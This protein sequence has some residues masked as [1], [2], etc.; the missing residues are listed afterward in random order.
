MQN[1]IWISQ[2][3]FL[4]RK[5]SPIIFFVALLS[6]TNYSFAQVSPEYPVSVFACVIHVL[7]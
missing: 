7:L 5:F 6:V 3:L 4:K 2:T 1:L